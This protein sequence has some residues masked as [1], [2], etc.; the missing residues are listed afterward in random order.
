[1]K[2]SI[3][4]HVYCIHSKTELSRYNYFYSVSKVH[5]IRSVDSASVSM[6][7]SYPSSLQKILFLSNLGDESKISV[8][9]FLIL[10]EKFVC[11]RIDSVGEPG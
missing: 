8:N 3:F 6:N 2:Y 10:S 4:R 5:S 11:F 9:D 7:I 1:M